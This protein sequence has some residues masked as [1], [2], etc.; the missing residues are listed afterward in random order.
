MLKGVT[1][2]RLSLLTLLTLA[3][4]LL[5]PLSGVQAQ[6]TPAV[7]EL[8]GSLAP[9][10][11]DVYRIVGLNKGQTLDAF[12]ENSSGNLDP[13]LAIM[14]YDENLSATLDSF[15]KAVAELVATSTQPLLDLPALR[16]KYS[17]AWNDDSGPGYSAALLFT[18]PEDGDY[19]LIASSSLSAAGRSTAGDY[20]LLLGL[21]APQVLD[22]TAK[23]TG[24]VIA[25]Q[26]QAI[27]GTHL[28]QELTGSLNADKPTLTVTLSDIK[29]GDTLY[30][31]LKATSGDLKP[32]LF[33]RDYGQKPI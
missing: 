30:I 3:I 22:G 23:P 17:L 7:Q 8:H 10:Q 16:D 12:M 11:I 4:I 5:A 14:P 32:I 33:L 31:T 15:K 28:V 13:V 29:P 20:R 27:L 1:A 18:A 2:M 19:Y 24:A 6:G 9:G 25:I 21:D 26:D